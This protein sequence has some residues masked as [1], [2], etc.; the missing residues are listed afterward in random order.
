MPAQSFL[1]VAAAE[2]SNAHQM[3]SYAVSQGTR[4]VV[5]EWDS[6]KAKAPLSCVDLAEG[7]SYFFVRSLQ[8]TLG[9]WNAEPVK[10]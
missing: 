6:I 10:Q 5:I 8:E 7:V 4:A 1:V 3:I 2:A 9:R